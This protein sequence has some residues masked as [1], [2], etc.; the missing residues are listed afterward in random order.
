MDTPPENVLRIVRIGTGPKETLWS[1]IVRFFTG[2]KGDSISFL[3]LKETK[4]AA[5]QSTAS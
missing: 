2:R 4:E 5:I 1:K 3:E